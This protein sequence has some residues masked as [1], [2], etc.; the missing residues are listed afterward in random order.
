MSL[1]EEQCGREDTQKQDVGSETQNSACTSKSHKSSITSKYNKQNVENGN[2]KLLDWMGTG[3]VVGEGKIASKDPMSKE[4][5]IPLCPDYWKIAV[6]RTIVED[7]LSIRPTFEFQ[8]L[9]HAIG[10]FIAWPKSYVIFD[11]V[12]VCFRVV[13]KMVW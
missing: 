5:H 9:G 13:E 7:T 10:S 11:Y 8:V 3:K 4:H 1:H 2:Y 12:L 6:T